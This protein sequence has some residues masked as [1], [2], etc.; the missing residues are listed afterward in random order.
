MQYGFR[1]FGITDLS[2]F[3]YSAWE[4]VSLSDRKFILYTVTVAST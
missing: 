2:I 3:E 4:I 1:I